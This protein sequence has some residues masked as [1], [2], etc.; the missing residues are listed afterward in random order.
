MSYIAIRQAEIEAAQIIK[1]ALER[2]KA[3]LAAP[4]K[5]AKYDADAADETVNE[6][7]EALQEA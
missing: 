7:L 2:A 6:I 3:V 1:D 4:Y 5:A